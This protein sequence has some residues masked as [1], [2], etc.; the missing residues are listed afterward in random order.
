MNERMKKAARALACIL[1]AAVI[2][3]AAIPV[4]PAHAQDIYPGFYS[5]TVVPTYQNPDTGEIDD[6]GQNPGIGNMMVQAQV[7]PVG[8]VEIEEDGTIWLNTRWNQADSS[9][10]AGFETSSDGSK[11]WKK[12]DFEVTNQFA[13]GDYE[14]MGNTFAATVTD[15]RFRL[16]SLN[17]TI[18]CSNYVEAMARDCIWF[19]Y[20]TDIREGVG[21]EWSVV[22]PPDMADYTESLSQLESGA[23]AAQS[24]AS[25]ADKSGTPEIKDREVADAKVKGSDTAQETGSSTGIVGL[26]SG[27]DKTEKDGQ[28]DTGFGVGHMVI[29]VVAGAV[30]GAVIIAIIFYSINKKKKSQPQ[31]NFEDDDVDDT[32]SDTEDTEDKEN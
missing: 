31:I 1:G 27:S 6:V 12:R 14:F 29:G 20:I 8:Y 23:P 28:K 30:I 2:T 19:C 16:D 24:E 32:A 21:D 18:R 26:D 10:Y 9:I 5:V 25:G 4:I 7:Q 13:A 3:I 22:A 15:Y 17:D 11:T